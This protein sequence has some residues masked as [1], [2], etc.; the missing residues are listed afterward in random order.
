MKRIRTIEGIIP[1]YLMLELVRRNPNDIWHSDTIKTTQQLFIRGKSGRTLLPRA[2]GTARVLVYDA[3]NSS[4]LPGV[5]A[6]FEGDPAVSD[7]AL[8]FI[9]DFA[10][11]VR[12]FHKEVL[13]IN[14][15]DN[16][17]SDYVNTGHYGQKYN[18]AFFNSV[19]MVFGDGDGVIFVTF[20]LPDIVGHEIGHWLTAMLCALEYFGQSGALNEHLSDVDGVVFRQWVKGPFWSTRIPG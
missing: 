17:G 7:A 19:Q 3:K 1:P 5:K 4:R 8:N 15:P 16:Q 13:K 9:Y 14:A 20:V 10:A 12:K 6:R 18:N 11:L 2:K